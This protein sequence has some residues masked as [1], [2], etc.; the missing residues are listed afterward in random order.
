MDSALAFYTDTVGMTILADERRKPDQIQQLWNLPPGTEARAAF[1]KG[2]SCSTMLQI[3]EFMPHS[4]KVIK[5]G[6]EAIYYGLY[7]IAFHVND[8]DTIYRDLVAKGF[9]FLTPPI[10][11]QPV[12][13]PYPVKQVFF[14]GPGNVPH[15]MIE[16]MTSQEQVSPQTFYRMGD[17]A[18]I[19]ASLDE[20]IKFYVDILGL[21]LMSQASVPE[22]L[23][24]ELLGLPE[25]TSIKLAF[26]NRKD[27]DALTVELVQPAVE[28]RFSTVAAR[29]PNL[30]LFMILF[31]VDDL[32]FLMERLEKEGIAVVSGPVELDTGLHGKMKVIT[33]EGP[34]SSLVGLFSR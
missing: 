29:P 2:E 26:V 16:R 23:L 27:T 15:S 4:G 13:T 30:G 1:L 7:D 31:E 24:E 28:G 12:F 14:L 5:Q 6:A 34:N 21:D 3:I 25:R 11:Y 8:M 20:V 33:V 19:V 17:S 18:Q 32:S 22:G 10:Q 9:T